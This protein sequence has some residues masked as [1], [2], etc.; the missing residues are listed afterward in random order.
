MDLFKFFIINERVDG[1]LDI[2]EKRNNKINLSNLL[3]ISI[4]SINKINNF[5]KFNFKNEKELFE[6]IKLK[7][8]K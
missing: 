4:F 8:Q 7:N 2:F 6:K 5:F 1:F 3:N